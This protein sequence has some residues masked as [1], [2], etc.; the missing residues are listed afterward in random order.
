MGLQPKY[1][2]ILSFLVLLIP[3]RTFYIQLFKDWIH[4]LINI[5]SRYIIQPSSQR[6]KPHGNKQQNKTS[7]DKSK[8]FLK[9]LE[10]AAT[11]QTQQCHRCKDEHNTLLWDG[12]GGR[13]QHWLPA[14]LWDCWF[15]D[16]NFGHLVL[17]HDE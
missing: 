4:L 5:E 10:S 14:V 16:V 12:I 11:W 6:I 3:C 13:P 15:S 17:V 8:V 1:L 2:K 7:F 9:V